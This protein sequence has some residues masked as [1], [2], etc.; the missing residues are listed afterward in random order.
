MK[1]RYEVDG[2]RAVAVLPV[3]FF[4]A[5]FSLFSGGY[6]GVDV[7]F[8]ISGYLIT[9][10]ILED[11]Q[12]GVF[13]IKRFYE[14][15]ARRILPALFFVML[16]CLPF[17]WA[18]MYVTDMVDFGKALG[19]VSIFSSNLLYLRLNGY[20]DSA[21][22]IKPLLHTWSLAVEEQFYFI[23]PLL[24]IYLVKVKKTV[25]FSILIL[26]LSIS[27]LSAEWIY[28]KN[29][30]AA[31]YLLPFR[32]WELISGSIVAWILFQSKDKTLQ[33]NIKHN[34]F[35]G[36]FAWLGLS[37]ILYAS[38]FY[39][40]NTPYPSVYTLAPVFGS[41][42]I[43]L[44]A[45]PERF[46][47]RLLGTPAFV[48]IGLVSYSAYLWHQP[49]FAFARL[50]SLDEPSQFIFILLTLLIMLL[51]YV[52]WRFVEAPFRA[53]KISRNSIF[54]L[55]LVG[56]LGF[57][58]LGIYIKN[59]NGAP[60]RLPA[61]YKSQF[62]PEKSEEAKNCMPLNKSAE[63]SITICEF[64]DVTSSRTLVLYG[65]SHAGA[66]MGSL[67]TELKAK[68]VRGIRLFGYAGC[69]VIP[70][71]IQDGASEDSLAAQKECL[72]GHQ[73]TIDYIKL[74]AEF[75]IVS[76]RWMYHLYPMPGILN[77]LAYDNGE[78]GVEYDVAMSFKAL[79]P[80]R[81][82]MVFDKDAKG[83][84]VNNLI[85]SFENTKKPFAIVYP[86]P[87]VGWNVPNYNFKY[88][89]EHG[90]PPQSISTSYE[91]FKERNAFINQLMDGYQGGVHLIRFKPETVLCNTY[92]LK[93]CV[94]Q[95]NQQPL[96]HDDDHLSNLGASLLIQPLLREM[97]IY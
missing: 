87:E 50:R 90:S 12:A 94:A 36:L 92:V 18:W 34:K 84:W 68:K 66:L 40:K 89:L 96:Y 25:A 81:Q 13:S 35:Y 79:S 67:D 65:D 78:G 51:A 32:G 30:A 7:F 64:G 43:L 97:K 27:F 58:C 70:G 22:E 16:S 17:A 83:Y 38:F 75:T 95:F 33:N 77:R 14:R 61:I 5:G 2:L 45:T 8:V 63:K 62:A 76:I 41:V 49:I 52:S 29:Q 69:N 46:V 59:S 47:G 19:A 71:L 6:V 93:R 9:T 54:L 23:F 28:P 85:S 74:N 39:S 1:Y 91:K 73:E 26:L 60:D 57:L 24:L 86:I 15:R 11:A 48:S 37:L 53:H 31:Y 56:I 80:D 3:I 44:F 20:F 82:R 10:I 55:S 21:A 88:F 72:R 4:H 42:L